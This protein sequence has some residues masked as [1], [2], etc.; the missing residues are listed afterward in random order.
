[1]NVSRIDHI[2]QIVRDNAVKIDQLHMATER[3]AAMHGGPATQQPAFNYRLVLENPDLGW[4][5]DTVE[6]A[7]AM[8]DAA[9]AP[10]LRPCHAIRRH[11]ETRVRILTPAMLERFFDNRNPRDWTDPVP[12]CATEWVS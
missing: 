1:M 9:A 4:P 2:S 5:A 7:R 3:L 11:G 10:H 6:L 8:R 12:V